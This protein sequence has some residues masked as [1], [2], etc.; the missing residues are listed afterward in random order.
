MGRGE[1]LL[2]NETQSPQISNSVFKKK[3]DFDWNQ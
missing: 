2:G 3:K 1:I